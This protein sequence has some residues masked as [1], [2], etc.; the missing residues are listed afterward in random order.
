MY[1]NP[2]HI[3]SNEIKI[4]LN[5]DEMRLIEALATFNQQQRAVF[6]RELMIDAL[7]NMVDLEVEAESRS[8]PLTMH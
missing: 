5:D 7:K 4:R 1:A 8:V 2:K 6:A 3:R